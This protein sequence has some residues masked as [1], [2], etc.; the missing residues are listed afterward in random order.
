MR[1]PDAQAAAGRRRR[2]RATAVRTLLCAVCLFGCAQM[3]RGET[4]AAERPALREGDVRR[5]EKVMA[6]LRLL[7][8][9]ATA[10]EGEASFRRL[11]RKFY[12]GL[13][14]TVADMRPSDLQTDLATAVFLYEDA[15]RAWS[16]RGNSAADC[17]GERP[18]VY[19]PLCL[20]L[21]GGTWRQL[22]VA[23]ARLHSRWAE[24]VVK[25]YKGEGDAETS[26]LL[27]EMRAAREQDI[28]I[29][30][31]VSQT[32]KSL[33]G[34]VSTSPNYA[35]YMEHRVA[36]KVGFERLEAEFADALSRVGAL[37]GWMPRSPVYYR[38]LS[39]WRCYKDGLF[40][41]R[42]VHDSRKLVVSAASGFEH[43][44]LTELRLSAEQVGYTAVVNW[45][46]AAKYTRLA[47]QS[48][49][50]AARSQAAPRREPQ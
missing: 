1:P 23:K 42:K 50:G 5:A 30:A 37:L 43:D 31:R 6:R 32:L 14:V 17:E 38:L 48:L 39:A 27:S 46:Q 28:L 25:T 20:G 24:A 11:A 13:F 3:S 10:Q 15:V 18:D 35:D 29:A 12:P 45:K 9:A 44:P 21:G 36:A 26:R 16:P 40:W 49:S 2:R 19:R 41:Y 8:G 34:M 4:A 33:E 47:E 22:L 7:G